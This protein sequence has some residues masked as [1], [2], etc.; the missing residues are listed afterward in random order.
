MFVALGVSLEVFTCKV[1]AEAG[2]TIIISAETVFGSNGTA[3]I[4]S[5]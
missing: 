2:R 4:A 5:N 1:W 3:T